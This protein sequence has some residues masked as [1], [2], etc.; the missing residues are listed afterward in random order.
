MEN[1]APAAD[2]HDEISLLDL[3]LTVSQNI[4]LLILGPL[5]AGLCALGVTFT[6]P[7]TYESV[8]ILPTDI[9]GTLRLGAVLDPVV[10]K[11]D[12]AKGKIPEQARLALSGRIKFA[13]DKQTKLYTL[14]VSGDSPQQAQ[15]TAKAL[16]MQVYE[17][18]RP[19]GGNKTRLENQLVGAKQRLEEAQ[20]ASVG[21]WAVL[22]RGNMSDVALKSTGSVVSK[23]Y[24]DFLGVLSLMQ[25]QVV[26]LEL[27]LEG[28]SD[29]QLLQAPSLP[30]KPVSQKEPMIATI[31]ALATGFALLLFVFIRQGL[32]TA[33]ADP[34]S[35]AKLAAIRR[36]LGFG[37]KTQA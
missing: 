14:T 3:L 7:A 23:I 29:E 17:Q 10:V 24:I 19:R 18:N 11:L 1:L 33:G 8:A 32:R 26:S 5:A 12:L 16:L 37:A 34:E 2:A 15:A 21:L 35:A 31:A 27:Q 30:E 13:Q 25:A 28:M 22:E 20:L 36:A 6:L 9:I 4:K